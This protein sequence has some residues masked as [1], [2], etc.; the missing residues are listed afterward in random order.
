MYPMTVAGL[1]LQ[2]LAQNHPC[3]LTAA[4]G[5]CQLGG[6][7]KWNQGGFIGFVES[8]STVVCGESGIHSSVCLTFP[9]VNGLHSF[10]LVGGMDLGFCFQWY[11]SPDKDSVLP[12]ALVQYVWNRHETS[13]LDLNMAKGSHVLYFSLCSCSCAFIV[14]W[15]NAQTF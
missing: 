9:K 15:I 7:T 2:E 5:T 11:C 1:E 10:E 8:K 6:K 3:G 13:S 14:M 4:Q 12:K